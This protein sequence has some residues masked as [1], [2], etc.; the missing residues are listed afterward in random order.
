MAKRFV[1]VDTEGPRPYELPI[2]VTNAHTGFEEGQ[3]APGNEVIQSITAGSGISIDAA[4]PSHIT[5][6]TTG[7]GSTPGIIVV[8]AGTNLSTARTSGAAIVYWIFSSPS[9]N[10][11]ASGENIVNAQPGDMWFVPDE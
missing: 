1:S 9:V 4:T 2:S 7:G 3:W 5:I 6:S 11:G 8:N 10:V